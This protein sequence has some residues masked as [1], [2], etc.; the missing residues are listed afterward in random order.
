MVI[1]EVCILMIKALTDLFYQMVALLLIGMI[2]GF[3]LFIG[4]TKAYEW[5]GFQQCVCD[6][7]LKGGVK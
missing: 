2:L 1:I 5:T 3:G 7:H 6:E 4:A